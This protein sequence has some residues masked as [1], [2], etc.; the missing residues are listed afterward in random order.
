[1]VGLFMAA[2]VAHASDEEVCASI[3]V[4]F[5]RTAL[6]FED[7]DENNQLKW[8]R[9]MSIGSGTAVA[10]SFAEDNNWPE[11]AVTALRAIQNAKNPREDGST[12][13]MV[14]AP[15]VILE[16][17]HIA[18]ET[19]AEKCPDITFPDFSVYNYILE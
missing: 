7:I 1:M 13:T 17:I 16:N 5:E 14:E 6:K 10:A 19:V 3:Q 4:S 8:L 15:V 11:E 9:I 12:L 18:M 2:P